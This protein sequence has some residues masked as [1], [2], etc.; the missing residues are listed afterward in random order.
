MSK[1]EV[2]KKLIELRKK[3]SIPADVTEV[4]EDKDND[5]TEPQDQQKV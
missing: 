5:E 3:L 1:E 2:E 4:I